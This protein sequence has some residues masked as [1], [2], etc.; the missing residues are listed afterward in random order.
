VPRVVTSETTIYSTGAIST[1]IA[2]FLAKARGGNE[3]QQSQSHAKALELFLRDVRM[4][5]LDHGDDRT[6]DYDDKIDEFRKQ[7]DDLQ[8][9]ASRLVVSYSYHTHLLPS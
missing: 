3:P 8:S 2:S 1:V 9:G 7:L 6:H 5:D 4:F